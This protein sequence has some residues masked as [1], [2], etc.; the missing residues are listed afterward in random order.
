MQ[1]AAAVEAVAAGLLRVPGQNLS[2]CH[3][4]D[5]LAVRDD[6]HAGGGAKKKTDC[7]HFG[8]D[9]L[10]FMT[11]AVLRAAVTDLGLR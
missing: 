6:L 1:P 7:T 11:E 5:A 8:L 9:A 10:L 3:V 4:Y 2:V